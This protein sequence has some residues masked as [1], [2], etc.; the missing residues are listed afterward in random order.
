MIVYFQNM[1]FAFEEDRCK[2]RCC[3]APIYRRERRF[4]GICIPD[5]RFRNNSSNVG[6]LSLLQILVTKGDGAG[7][8]N[9][10]LGWWKVGNRESRK[11]ARIM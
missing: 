4:I 5:L 2:S 1:Y 8:S 10:E 11:G 7:N 3:L 6:L 9:Y